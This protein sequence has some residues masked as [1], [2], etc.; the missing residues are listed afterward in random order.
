MCPFK[1]LFSTYESVDDG[2]ILLGNNEPCKVIGLRTIKLKMHDR[3]IMILSN[4]CHVPELKENLISLGT[5]DANGCKFMM[6]LRW[7]YEGCLG[8][9]CDYEGQCS[10]E[11]VCV[12]R[13]RRSVGVSTTSIFD[14]DVT[15]L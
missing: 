1:D 3:V 9:S 10:W 7:S 13:F 6:N 2:I 8:C 11:L 5:L 4:V 12:A 15:K 14:E